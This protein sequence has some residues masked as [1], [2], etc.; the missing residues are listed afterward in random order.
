MD[1]PAKKENSAI[2]GP[3]ATN[4]DSA[5][6]PEKPRYNRIKAALAEK[7]ITNKALALKLGVSRN[8]VSNWCRNEKQPDL[9]TLFEIAIAIGV[10]PSSLISTISNAGLLFR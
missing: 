6:A 10:E 5:N 2:T 4:E 8:T 3:N 9:P 1:N 7:K